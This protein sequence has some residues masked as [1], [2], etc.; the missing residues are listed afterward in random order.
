MTTPTS[1]LPEQLPETIRVYLAAHGARDV[2]AALRAFTPTAVVVDDG[3]TYRGTEEVRS[4]LSKAGAEFSYTTELVAAER[5]DDARW[6]AIHR[7][8]GDFPGGVVELHHRF[9]MDGDR[10]AE[11]VIAP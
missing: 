4:F 2:D 7:L 11:L 1:I 9:T 8:E 3:T 10:V 6:V 5:V